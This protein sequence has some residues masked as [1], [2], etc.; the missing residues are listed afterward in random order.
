LW[1]F[2]ALLTQILSWDMTVRDIKD[3]AE[4]SE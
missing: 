3:R 2:R 4:N 1:V